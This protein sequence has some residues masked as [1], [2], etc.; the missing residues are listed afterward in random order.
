MIRV[1]V[2]I[3][4]ISCHGPQIDKKTFGEFEFFFLPKHNDKSKNDIQFII[5]LCLWPR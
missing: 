2:I 4:K 5:N 1:W 3:N